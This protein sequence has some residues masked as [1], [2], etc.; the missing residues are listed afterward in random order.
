MPDA[1]PLPRGLRLGSVLGVPVFVMPSWFVLAGLLVVLLSPPLVD[2][3]GPT[4]AY[5]VTTSFAV[6]LGLSVL[7]HEIGH[8][9]VARAFALPVRSIT[10]TFLAG[11]TEIVRPPQTPAR[12]YAVAIAGPIVSLLLAA[13]GAGLLPLFD[14][15]SVS[16]RIALNL[17]ITNGLIA[18]LNLLPG[19]PLDGG[20]V[21][22]SILWRVTGDPDRATRGAAWSGR[23]LGLLILPLVLLVALPALGYGD[24]GPV[25]IVFAALLGSYVYTLATIALRQGQAAS[26]L[27]RLSARSLTRPALAVPADLPLAEAVRQANEAGVH[28]LVVVD[29]AGRLVAVVSEAA[30]LATPPARRPWVSVGTLAR[31]LDESL[32]LDADLSGTELVQALQRHPSSEYVVRDQATGALGVLSASDVSRALTQPS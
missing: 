13:T 20:R 15:D 17:A 1:D 16:G 8:C 14:D 30:V 32:V 25:S 21:L 19:L 26:R 11:L 12:E 3:L 9:V 18:V 10:I 22:R 24:A 2:S 7:L 23:V 6:L 28:G 4:Q 27:P 29:G 5:A 31:S